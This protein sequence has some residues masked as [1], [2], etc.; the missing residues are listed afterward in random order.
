MKLDIPD[1]YRK[2]SEYSETRLDDLR[3]RLA[4]MPAAGRIPGLT[5]FVAGSYAR[6]EASAHSDLDPFFVCLGDRSG[7]V[8]SRTNELEM[9]GNLIQIG[10]DMALPKFSADCRYLEV[11]AADDVLLTLGSPAD[12]ARNHFT[13]RLLMLLESRPIYGADL[14]QQIIETFV[15]SYFR[16][17]PDHQATFE[18]TF[19]LNDILRYWRTVLGNY[20]HLRNQKGTEAERIQQKIKNFK[21][22]YSRLTTCFA[23]VAALAALES[24]I[25]GEDVQEIIGLTPHQRLVFIAERHQTCIPDVQRLITGYATFLELTEMTVPEL[26]EHFSDKDRRADLFR[27]ATTYGD[28][29]FELLRSLDEIQPTEQ[30]RL[31]R[32]LVV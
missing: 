16:D 14:Y 8:Q 7:E 2:R 10:K 31:L 28:A 9:F 17:Y 21:L 26:E 20:E 24:P 27:E 11:H 19:L 5:I 12:D 32:T 6:L 1:I 30:R 3:G 29:F 18:P 22:K 23:T 4:E 13:L 25:A 15:G